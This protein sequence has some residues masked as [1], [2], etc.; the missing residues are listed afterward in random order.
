MNSILPQLEDLSRH[1]LVVEHL[2]HWTIADVVSLWCTT[3]QCA[4]WSDDFSK[5]PQLLFRCLILLALRPPVPSLSGTSRRG[6]VH[7]TLVPFPDFIPQSLD[8]L[9]H[10][11]VLAACSHLSS[12]FH[13]SFPFANLSLICL[14]CCLIYLSDT[15]SMA[16]CTFR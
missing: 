3:G 5:S 7:L 9:A 4:A 6:F 2:P 1:K 11:F 12:I 8:A 15:C 16:H 13:R 10:E 14:I